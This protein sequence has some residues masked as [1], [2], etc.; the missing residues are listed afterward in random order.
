MLGAL[1]KGNENLTD[2]LVRY[3]TANHRSR[4]DM[5]ASDIMSTCSF[6]KQVPDG[7][8]RNRVPLEEQALLKELTGGD[9]MEHTTDGKV[10]GQ[11]ADALKFYTDWLQNKDVAGE[12]PAL[13]HVNHKVNA[14][15]WIRD[16]HKVDF[17]IPNAS[18]PKS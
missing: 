11:Q 14:S 1:L 13:I 9:S 12:L 7:N 16:M 18:A 6:Y 10:D 5:A 4:A 15:G 8:W 2:F 17:Q 3:R